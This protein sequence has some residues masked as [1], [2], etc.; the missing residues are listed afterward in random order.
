MLFIIVILALLTTAFIYNGQEITW[1]MP[2]GIFIKGADK[3]IQTQPG[4]I[5][6]VIDGKGDSRQIL[7]IPPDYVDNGAE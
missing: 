1:T 5:L 4:D 7:V 2:A 6:T 3:T